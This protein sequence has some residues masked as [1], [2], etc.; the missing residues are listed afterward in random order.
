MVTL[1]ICVMGASDMELAFI[2][3]LFKQSIV[4]YCHSKILDLL[5]IL[6]KLLLK[7]KFKI[8]KNLCVCVCIC[9]SIQENYFY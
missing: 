4:S 7:T 2:N 3:S 9:L 8:K 1:S 5:I 6:L